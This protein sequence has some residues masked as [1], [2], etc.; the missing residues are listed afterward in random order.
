[1]RAWSADDVLE[2]RNPQ[3]VRPWQHV[4]EP[5]QGYLQLAEQ[6]WL[7]PEL[8]GAYNFGPLTQEVATVRELVELA[9]QTYGKGDIHYGKDS[10]GLH[11]A[12]WL[13]L[14][15]SKARM[16]LNVQPKWGLPEAVLRTVNWYQ[17]QESGADTREL[18][19][20]D[21][22]KYVSSQGNEVQS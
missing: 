8:A 7:C 21:I 10:N 9:L 3:A 18:C 15:T 14:E 20:A 1:M 12:N 17:A 13:A 22:Q 19:L 2:I 5:L 11:E 6:L 16:V 4:L